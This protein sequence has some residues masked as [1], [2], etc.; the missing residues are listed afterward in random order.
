[1]QKNS[2]DNKTSMEEM[3]L[4]F[5]KWIGSTSSLVVHSIFFILCMI[6]PLFG[7]D[8]DRVLLFL[9]TLVSLEAI[10]LGIFIQFTVNQSNENIKKVEEDIDEIQEDID[11]IQE[12]V[13]EI[14]EDIDEIQEDVDEIEEGEEQEEKRDKHVA[15]VMINIQSRLEL[16]IKDIEKIKKPTKLTL[17]SNSKQINK[18]YD[19]KGKSGTR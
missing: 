17:D 8:F 1:M 15:E 10:Y 11:E 5:T 16:L 14:Q 7:L 18:I 13:G 2:L 9:T 3:A 12:D 19:N 4:K 6:L